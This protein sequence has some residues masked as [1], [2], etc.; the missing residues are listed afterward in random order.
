MKPFCQSSVLRISLLALAAGISIMATGCGMGSLQHTDS[1]PVA[2]DAIGGHV[3]GGQQPVIGSTVQLWVAGSTNYG[4]G[5]TKLGAS[6]QTQAPGGS[7]TLGAYT[8]PSSTAQ[9]YIT[10][11]SGNPGLSANNPQIVLAAALGNCGSLTASTYIFIDEVTTAATAFALGQYF[12][13]TFGSASTDGFGA[14][15]T[16]QAQVGLVNAFAT[17][18]NLVTNNTG[19]AVTSATLTGAG[20]SVTTTPESAKLYTIANILAA[21]VNSPGGVS[22]DSSACGTLFADVVPTSSTAPTDTLQA[23]VY[24]SL[25]PTSNN[26]NGSAANLAQLYTLP[27]TTA[28]YTGLSA[29]PTDWTLGILYS[30]STTTILEQPH[31]LAVDSAGNIWVASGTTSSELTELS[32]LGV[33]LVNLTT[34]GAVALSGLSPRNVAVDTNNNV[35]MTTSSSSGDVF[36]YMPAGGTA[37]TPVGLGKA[38]YGLA[39]DGNNNV[40]VGEESTSSTFELAEFV[41]GVL[42]STTNEVRYPLVGQSSIGTATS[43]SATMNPEYL[44]FDSSTPANLWMSGGTENGTATYVYQLSNISYAVCGAVPFAATCTTTTSSSSVNT[45]TSVG[46]GTIL[47]PVGLAASMSGTTPQMWA[48]N[49]AGTSMDL[50]NLTSNSSAVAGGTAYG[51]STNLKGAFYVAVD[52]AGNAWTASSSSTSPGTVMEV[53]SAGTVLSPNNT[54]TTPF[55]VIG[56]SHVGLSTALGIAV[57]P[58][59]NVWVANNIASGTSGSAVFEIVGAAAPT[60]TPIA[61]ALNEGKVAQ[62]P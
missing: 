14:P 29:Q 23:A 11:T 57:D 50:L 20:G 27:P 54:G 7:F 22:G 39:I 21:C 10:A 62:K 2:G 42:N 17:Y 36:E 3:H 45:Y 28:P 60:V 30:G 38:S 19:N 35:W 43:G 6:V 32:P 24:M 12:T 44:A 52:G 34:I 4:V 56:F 33:P 53:N 26:A 31:S 25:N 40:W 41:G 1:L 48:V 49:D 59:G 5:A 61:L 55:N 58:S 51:N 8:C 15:N 18:N 46:N 16:T 13:P 37:P 47:E 9:T